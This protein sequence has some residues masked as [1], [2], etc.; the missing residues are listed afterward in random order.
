MKNP[1]HKDDYF[2]STKKGAQ[3]GAKGGALAGGAGGLLHAYLVSKG[4]SGLGPRLLAG[5][6]GG[7][8]A[9]GIQGLLLGGQLGLIHD[10]FRDHDK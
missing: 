10:I 2:D 8:A 3:L 1:F 4:M 9:G 5:G 7:T 6:L